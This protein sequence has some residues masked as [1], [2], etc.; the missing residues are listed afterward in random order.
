M[1]DNNDRNSEQWP[2]D[3]VAPVGD[4]LASAQLD[5]VDRAM[6]KSRLMARVRDENNTGNTVTIRKSDEGWEWF[7]PRVKI[8]VLRSDPGSTSYLLKLEAGA[9]VWPHRHRQDE[10]CMVL[11][12]EI[13]I[14]EEK[15]SAG[16]YHLAPAGMIHQPIRSETGATLFLRGVMP[17]FR[18]LAV[19]DAIRSVF[20]K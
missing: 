1:I 9:I 11:E 17:S 4:A 18:D 5:P 20:D 14:G 3:L 12:G 6:M 16:A 7:S 13:S 15:A 19:R 2:D 8:K 10:E